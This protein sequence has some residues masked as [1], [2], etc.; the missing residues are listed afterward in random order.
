VLASVVRD[1]PK[2]LISK[3][4]SITLLLT[5]HLAARTARMISHDANS[6]FYATAV[7]ESQPSQ[8]LITA[9]GNS[10]VG[11]PMN[12]AIFDQGIFV[13]LGN[14]PPDNFHLLSNRELE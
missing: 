10:E 13:D 6:S 8:G 9:Q 11:L 14:V 7:L 2:P 1:T 4:K 3:Q 5:A 12:T